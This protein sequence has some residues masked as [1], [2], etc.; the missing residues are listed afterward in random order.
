MKEEFYTGSLWAL[1]KKISPRCRDPP[2]AMLDRNGNLITSPESIDILA[3]ETYKERLQNRKMKPNLSQLQ[4][5]K[6]E[7]CIYRY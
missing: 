7:L 5:E 2:T 4:T 6:E 3:L 1:K